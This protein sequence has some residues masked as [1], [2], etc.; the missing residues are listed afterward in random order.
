MDEKNND[1]DASIKKK[2]SWGCLRVLGITS[3]CLLVIIIIVAGW[4]KYN[5]Y[6]SPYKHT[7]LSLKEQKVLDSKLSILSKSQKKEDRVSA[8]RQY[9]STAS[10]KP[11]PYTE[12][13]A[14]R[15]IS[16]TEKELNSLITNYPEAAE[17]VAI[18]LSDELISV[19]LVIPVDEEV[20]FLGGKTLRL[21]MGIIL[22]YENDKPVV[23]I[24]GISLGGI[25]LP[26]AW[27][28]YTKGKNLVEEFGTE[29]GFWKLFAEGVKDI[30]VK[31]GQLRIRLQE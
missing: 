1:I 30:K 18:D 3:I 12:E 28:G 5:I 22:S 16:L 17:K 27:I 24:K 31:E 20:I 6:A 25:P 23:G 2:S 14:S 26:N 4:I 11:E 7:K 10:L 29:T 13:G 9:Q 15:E 21:N 8:N 19:K